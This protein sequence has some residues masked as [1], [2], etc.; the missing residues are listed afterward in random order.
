MKPVYDTDWANQYVIESGVVKPWSNVHT[1]REWRLEKIAPKQAVHSGPLTVKSPMPGL[2]K[3]VL[4]APGD[5][6]E[7]GARL[8]VLEAMKMEN[9]ITAARSGRI[10]E[11]NV[12]AGTI[13]EGGLP[14]ITIE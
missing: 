9:E 8:L 7:K 10:V 4:V 5:E 3:E 6:V 13:V 1:E 14:L 11:V 12:T 2:V